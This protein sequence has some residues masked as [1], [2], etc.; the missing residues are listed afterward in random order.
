MG[1]DRV[2]ELCHQT[3]HVDHVISSL[4]AAASCP[5]ATK[6]L[7]PGA[8]V[9]ADGAFVV[10]VYSEHDVVQSQQRETVVEHQNRG[11]RTIALAPAILL[12]DEDVE[13]GGL[14]DSVYAV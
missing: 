3:V 10:A 9:G 5:T 1:Q 2:L 6:R 11:F 8:Q 7:E 13:L 14:V 12:T 4:T